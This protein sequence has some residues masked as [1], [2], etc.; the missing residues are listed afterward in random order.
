MYSFNISPKKK[1]SNTGCN[2]SRIT[3][4]QLQ[5]ELIDNPTNIYNSFNIN[6]NDNY[7]LKCIVN[8]YNIL[9]IKNGLAGVK[10]N[11]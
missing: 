5:V 3:N 10:Y 4:P 9:I 1:F 7:E 8:N 11:N 6:V 2:F